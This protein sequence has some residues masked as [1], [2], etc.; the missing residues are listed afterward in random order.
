MARVLIG[1]ELGAGLGHVKRLLAVARG[2][3]AHGYQPVFVLRNLVEPW[4]ALRDAPFPLIQAPQWQ[5]R[6]DQTGKPFRAAAISDIFAMQGFDN[7]DDLMPMVE[8]WQ[9][10]INLTRP[11]LIISDYSPTLC[12]AAYGVNPMVIVG[13]GFTMPPHDL[14][15]FPILRPQFR[16]TLPQKRMLGVI[17]EVQRRRNRPSPETLPGLFAAEARYVCTLPE[18]DPYRA[19]R[20]EKVL[21][22]FETPPPPA[23]LPRKP[24]FFSYIA[25]DF[26]GIKNAVRGLAEIKVPGEIYIRRASPAMKQALRK[27]GHHVHDAPAPLLDVLRNASAIIHHGGIGTTEAAVGIGRPQVVLPRHME[28]ELTARALEELGVGVKVSGNFAPGAVADALNTVIDD[29]QF[30]ERAGEFAET[31]RGRGPIDNVERIVQGCLRIVSLGRAE[32]TE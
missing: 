19:E 28:Q 26:R 25:S 22:P 5:P 32:R 12:L 13:D 29:P 18:L 20:K 17:A 6:P 9:N 27:R 15:T 1:W 24:R 7:P 14:P 2:L 8:G 4:P 3:A 21:G 11:D 16:E 10:L 30:A 23:P 31:L